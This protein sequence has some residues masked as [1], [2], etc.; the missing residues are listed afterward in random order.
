MSNS[1]IIDSKHIFGSFLSRESA[2]HLMYGMVRKPVGG[3]LRIEESEMQIHAKEEV[4]SDSSKEETSHETSS[5]SGDSITQVNDS[6]IE[7]KQEEVTFEEPSNYL[8]IAGIVITILLLIL[9][10][11]LLRK[12]YFLEARR[13]GEVAAIDGDAEQALERN[14]RAVKHL[15]HKLEELQTIVGSFVRDSYSKEL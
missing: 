1:Q 9:S 6:L 11:F 13:L 15:R 2:F 12:I 3:D 4:P 14:L 5:L 10:T 8:L 7:E